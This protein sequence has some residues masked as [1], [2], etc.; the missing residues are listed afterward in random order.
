MLPIALLQSIIWGEVQWSV[1]CTVGCW[2]LWLATLVS[3]LF[4]ELVTAEKTYLADPAIHCTQF[5][6]DLRQIS[7]QQFFLIPVFLEVQDFWK[8]SWIEHRHYWGTA[9]HSNLQ[10]SKR[11]FVTCLLVNRS[12]PLNNDL[13]WHPRASGLLSAWLFLSWHEQLH[14]L[15]C[16]TLYWSGL[17]LPVAKAACNS[18]PAAM[19]TSRITVSDCFNVDGQI[20]QNK[21]LQ[22]TNLRAW[23]HATS[24]QAHTQTIR[25]MTSNAHK[26]EAQ[27]RQHLVRIDSV[28]FRSKLAICHVMQ[29]LRLQ[30][31]IH[32]SAGALAY[33]LN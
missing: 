9:Q 22:K 29:L 14:T 27:L 3:F 4:R 21:Q 31:S 23:K 25:T 20:V 1:K 12:L 6:M 19:V 5:T 32:N 7:V 15:R 10:E 24:P 17:H 26:N 13:F 28:Y 8:V 18:E 30:K 16:D 11:I 2:R 33:F